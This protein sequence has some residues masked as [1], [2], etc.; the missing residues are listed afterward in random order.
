MIL[1]DLEYD[2]VKYVVILSSLELGITYFYFILTDL[3]VLGLHRRGL[4]LRVRLPSQPEALQPQHRVQ[5]LNHLPGHQRHQQQKR[6][7]WGLLLQSPFCHLLLQF[8]CFNALLYWCHAV[9]HW[10]DWM[11]FTGKAFFVLIYLDR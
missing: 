5:R 3:R 10:K 6:H 7:Q 8:L 4:W 1:Q 2:T 11:D 9:D